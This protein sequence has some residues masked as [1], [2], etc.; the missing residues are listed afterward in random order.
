M[1]RTPF[2]LSL[3][4]A[5]L[6]GCATSGADYQPIIDPKGVNPA[7]YQTDLS[8]CQALAEQAQTAGRAAARDAAAGAA[9][10][11][12]VGAIGGTVLGCL[13][14]GVLNNGLFLL[15]VSP[16][17]QQVIKGAVLMLAVFLDVYYK[18]KN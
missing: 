10:G 18:N 4:L 11:A 14:I 9:V 16:F 6:T 13:I 17:W 8:E 15:N 3:V 12:V 7:Q 2:V 5:A 1:T